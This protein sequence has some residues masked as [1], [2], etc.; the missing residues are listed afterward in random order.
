[1]DLRRAVGMGL[2]MC[3]LAGSVGCATSSE[4][5]LAAEDYLLPAGSVPLEEYQ[6]SQTFQIATLGAGDALGR[7]IYVNDV[8]LAALDQV[9]ALR[10]AG[11]FVEVPIDDDA[12]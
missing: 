11:V 6:G 12:N 7:A 2:A 3:G 8:I 9:G 5:G 10:E 4:S 1:M